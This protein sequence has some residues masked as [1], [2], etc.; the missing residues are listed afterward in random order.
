MLEAC[1]CGR[2]GELEDRKPVTDGD[3]REAPR[4]SPVRAPGPSLLAPGPDSRVRGGEA[5]SA[6]ASGLGGVGPVARQNVDLA[7]A[8][9]WTESVLKGIDSV[10]PR[11]RL[12]R[13]ERK[14]HELPIETGSA[15]MATLS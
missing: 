14:T 5:P 12:S 2:T 11:L 7:R 10:R 13:K 3:G 9:P 8:S 1:Y 4:V 15:S 6:R